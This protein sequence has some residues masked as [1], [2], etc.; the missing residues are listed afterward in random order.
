MKT[1]VKVGVIGS[2]EVARAL[3]LGFAATGHPVMLSN[4]E[5]PS[6]ELVLWTKAQGDLVQG[7]SFSEAA[8][9]GETIVIATL[10]LAT[11]QA[12]KKAG[13]DHFT[14]KVVMDATNPLDFSKGFPPLLAGQVGDSGGERI[15]RLLTKSQVVKVF[16]TVGNKVMFK[17]RFE[18]GRPDMFI[19]GD[20]S[21]AKRHCTHIL[22]SFGWNAVD[23][24]GINS[25]HYLE[26][27]AMIW[28]LSATFAQP[29]RWDQAFKML[30]HT[31]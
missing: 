30:K 13:L 7:G 12:I 10:G 18:G 28:I 29:Q 20:D 22:D 21:A 2:G 16:N 3:T 19:C 23:V 14:D 25:C 6:D 9:F 5:K 31:G 17:P 1:G 8:R 15:Q 11:E 26:A 24:G 4:R 27:M